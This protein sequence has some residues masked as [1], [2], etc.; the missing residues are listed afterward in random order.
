MRGC[1]S[2]SWPITGSTINIC[3][4]H[5]VQYK[6]VQYRS[7][8]YKSVQYKSVQY[9]SVQYK[10]VQYKTVQYKSVQYTLVSYILV[11]DTQCIE[12]TTHATH[13]FIQNVYYLSQP[14]LRH[15]LS[16]THSLFIL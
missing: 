8:Q 2:F 12:R 10:S 9:K 16:A 15:A 7:V 11:K 14:S 5:S 4:I 13:D 6:S 1:M 3:T